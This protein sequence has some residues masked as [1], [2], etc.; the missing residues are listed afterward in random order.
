MFLGSLIGNLGKCGFSKFVCLQFPTFCLLVLVL[1]INTYLQTITYELVILMRK[2]TLP[3]NL[4]NVMYYLDKIISQL[5]WHF[6][7]IALMAAE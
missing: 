4:F 3:A 6:G 7:S 1:L 2:Y 5:H